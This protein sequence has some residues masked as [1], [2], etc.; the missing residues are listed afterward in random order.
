MPDSQL[1]QRALPRPSQGKG[2][3][4]ISRTNYP[5][6]QTHTHNV[7]CLFADSRIS[8]QDTPKKQVLGCP[9]ASPMVSS[10]VPPPTASRLSLG[11]STPILPTLSCLWVPDRRRHISRPVG[12]G[13]WE[14]RPTPSRSDSTRQSLRNGA[15]EWGRRPVSHQ[16][17]EGGCGSP[18]PA[19]PWGKGGAESRW[20]QLRLGPSPACSPRPEDR[21][22][23]L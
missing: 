1:T 10:S 5:A 20:Q 7:F 6:P 2:F 12:E 13:A 8:L 15:R 22:R 9:K 23:R 4:K 19:R 11:F 14:G 3:P 18:R 17:A 16:A 21:L